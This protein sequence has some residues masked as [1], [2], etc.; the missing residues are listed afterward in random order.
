MEYYNNLSGDDKQI[1]AVALLL[2]EM[3]IEDVNEIF[4]N[5][6]FLQKDRIKV[7]LHL[8]NEHQF[9][10]LY[11]L[12]RKKDFQQFDH[13]FEEATVDQLAIILL[14]NDIY[15][16]IKD[17][18]RVKITNSVCKIFAA[19]LSHEMS[20]GLDEELWHTSLLIDVYKLDKEKSTLSN[21]SIM[22]RK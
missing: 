2:N 20:A 21:I 16:L 19:L 12:L 13:F 1:A 6:L 18:S 22:K 14:S 15:L 3:E 17:I 5:P 7:F 11:Q 10:F 9:G 4:L 8:K